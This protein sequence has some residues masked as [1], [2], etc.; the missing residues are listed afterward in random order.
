MKETLQRLEE[1]SNS[2]VTAI[3]ELTKRIAITEAL[4]TQLQEQHT[5]LAKQSLSIGDTKRLNRI[6]LA[7]VLL[8]LLLSVALGAG[9]LQVNSNT[10]N[11]NDIQ[12]RTSNEVLCP[13]YAL[14]LN[15]LKQPPDKPRSKQQEEQ[16]KLFLK[17]FEEGY[18]TLNCH[19]VK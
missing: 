2:L 8:D 1:T 15:L 11:I 17:T 7:S 4:Q 14:W 9:F 5:E 10:D 6:L 16:A 18:K 3:H 19:G 13:Q 12:N